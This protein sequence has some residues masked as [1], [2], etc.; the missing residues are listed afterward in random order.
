MRRDMYRTFVV[1]AAL[2]V[3]GSGVAAAERLQVAAE[4]HEAFDVGSARGTVGI[5]QPQIFRAV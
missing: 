1:V 4:A 3:P 2:F 5:N